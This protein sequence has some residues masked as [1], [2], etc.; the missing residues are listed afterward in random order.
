MSGRRLNFFFSSRRRHTR[1]Q[2]DWSSD[3][4]SSDLW[5]GRELRYEGSDEAQFPD[6][7]V[8]TEVEYLTGR[9]AEIATPSFNPLDTYRVDAQSWTLMGKL[10][11]DVPLRTPVRAVLGRVPFLEPVSIYLGSGAGL[12]VSKLSV[13]T[14]VLTGKD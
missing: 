8:R 4:C 1:L 12:G 10:R 14:G 7:E 9:D 5:P 6:W 2:G 13:N 3:V 11:L